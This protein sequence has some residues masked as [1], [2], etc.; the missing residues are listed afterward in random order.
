MEILIKKLEIF[1]ADFMGMFER[2]YNIKVIIHSYYFNQNLSTILYF[3]YLLKKYY[4]FEI[5]Q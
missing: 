1:S 2:K 3:L 5:I 4:S